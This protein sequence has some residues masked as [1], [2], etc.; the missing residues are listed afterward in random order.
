MQYILDK[1]VGFYSVLREVVL[2]Y[3]FLANIHLFISPESRRFYFGRNTNSTNSHSCMDTVST[4]FMCC[5]S[6]VKIKLNI[7][8]C[9]EL[10]LLFALGCMITALQGTLVFMTD[11]HHCLTGTGSNPSHHLLSF[12]PSTSFWSYSFPCCV[13]VRFLVYL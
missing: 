13:F 6:Q 1:V 8:N 7:L 3:S 11:A 10:Y 2:T 5:R 4:F 9:N 12:V